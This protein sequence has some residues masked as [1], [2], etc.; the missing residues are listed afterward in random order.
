ERRTAVK[1]WCF[2]LAVGV[3]LIVCE[4]VRGD[5]PV[6][7]KSPLGTG[8]NLG[9]VLGDLG[10]VGTTPVTNSPLSRGLGQIVSGWTHDGIHGQELAERIHWLQQ[11][12]RLDREQLP[13]FHD[14]GDFWQRDRDGRWFRDR[15]IRD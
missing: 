11:A 8:A 6:L 12:R 4:R 15:E 5:D 3:P 13:F 14:R 10:R 2:L 7:P 1:N 9:Q